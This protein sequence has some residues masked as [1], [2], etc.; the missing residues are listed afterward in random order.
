MSKGIRLDKYLKEMRVATRSEA[1]TL[2]RDGHVNV[3]GVVAKQGRQS[4]DPDQDTVL[5][6][7]QPVVYQRYF[8]FLLNKPVAVVTA[9]TDKTA[10]TVMDLFNKADYRDDLFPVGR[11]DKDTTGAL[12]ITNNGELGHRLTNPKHHVTKVYQTIVT[13]TLT[14]DDVAQVAAGITLK[15]GTVLKPADMKLD[16]YDPVLDQ[17][18]IQLTLTEGKYHQVKR[19]VGSFG[20]RVVRLERLSFGPLKLSTG[21]LPGH[22]RALSEEEV[23]ALKVAA[24]LTQD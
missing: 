1:H 13:G 22:Y 20:Q 10:Q 21:L 24:D 23:N 18:T 15:D 11:L 3:N 17:T 5:V 14:E 8:Y 19:M 9:T 16:A 2:I 6:G 12:L 4:I 7:G